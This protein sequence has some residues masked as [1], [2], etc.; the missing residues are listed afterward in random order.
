MITIVDGD[1]LSTDC[2]IIA[3][4]VNC[5]GLMDHGVAKQLRDKYPRN[6]RIYKEVCSG[7]EDLGNQLADKLAR[8]ALDT[9][10]EW[11]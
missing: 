11:E 9:R 6:Y 4:Q 5:K 1:L 10:K 3:H 7:A 8:R 2:K